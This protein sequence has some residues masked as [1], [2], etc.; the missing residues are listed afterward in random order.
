MNRTKDKN[1]YLKSY[2]EINKWLNTCVVC[3]STGYKPEL[4]NSIPPGQLAQNIRK[5]WNELEVNDIG[6]CVQ[7]SAHLN[8]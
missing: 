7:C 3:Q 8:A 1:L 2:P 5:Y 6:I 4:P